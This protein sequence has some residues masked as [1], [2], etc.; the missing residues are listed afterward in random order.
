MNATVLS[1]T[2]SYLVFST[3]KGIERR[4]QALLGKKKPAGLLNKAGDSLEVV[5]LVGEL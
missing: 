3:F 1:A 4:S 2:R 5:S